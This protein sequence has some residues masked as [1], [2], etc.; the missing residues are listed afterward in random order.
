MMRFYLG[1]WEIRRYRS[2]KSPLNIGYQKADDCTLSLKRIE[3]ALERIKL[4]GKRSKVRGEEGIGGQ[5]D[6]VWRY[7]DRKG[8]ASEQ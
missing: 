6:E 4:R 5:A 7:G 8:R 3:F 2:G 1:R